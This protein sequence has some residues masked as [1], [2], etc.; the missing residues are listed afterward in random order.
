[1]KSMSQIQFLDE[2]LCISLDANAFRK[3]MYP[4]VLSQ[5]MGKI[6]FLDS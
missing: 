4:F 6:I 5:A 3:G 1:M 2:V